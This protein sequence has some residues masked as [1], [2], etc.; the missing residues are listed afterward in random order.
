MGIDSASSNAGY[1]FKFLLSRCTKSIKNSNELEY[2]I[3][4]DNFMEDVITVL[5]Y[6][7]WPAAKMIVRI[8]SKIMIGYRKADNYT[9]SM[10]IDYLGIIAGRIKKFANTGLISG[11]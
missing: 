10:A 1:V 5:N 7:K 3:L 9:K 2:R 4:L 11:E 8:F 6:P